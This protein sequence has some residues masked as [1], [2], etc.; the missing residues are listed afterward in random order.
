MD[1]P[2]VP[3][4]RVHLNVRKDQYN[5]RSSII[6]PLPWFSVANL[7]FVY[8]DYKHDEL[9]N[10]TV[11]ATFKTNGVDSRIELVHQ[12]IGL[13]EGSIGSQVFYKELSVLGEEAF[14]QPTHNFGCRRIYF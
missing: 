3:P 14:L 5:V 9:D 6:D 4:A 8:T 1:E 7:K 10:N 13:F 2:G 11:G 12:P